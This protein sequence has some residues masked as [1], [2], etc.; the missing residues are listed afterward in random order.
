MGLKLKFDFA[1]VLSTCGFSQE[2]LQKALSILTIAYSTLYN[3]QNI[4]ISK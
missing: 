2:Y 1:G 4:N 3:S